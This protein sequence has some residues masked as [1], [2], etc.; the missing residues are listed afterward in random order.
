MTF[1]YRASALIA[2]LTCSLA[3][4]TSGCATRQPQ[5]FRLSFLPSTPIPIEPTFEAPPQFPTNLY[6]SDTP[7]L[8]QRALALA[9]RQAE[10]NSRVAKAHEH[11]E[12]GK[13]FYQ[14]N[15]LDASRREFDAALDVLL[16]APDTLPDRP[17]LEG[18]LDQIADTIYH[19]D[20][21]GLGA[22]ASGQSEV[23]YD[24]SP[25]DGILDMTF[26]TD[27]NL[28]PKV[29]EEIAA[30]VS[31][32]PLQE[33]D[34]VLSYVHYFSTDRGRQVLLGGLRRSGRYRSLVQRILD[35]E[36]VP[37]ELIY[38][39][40][41]ESG[42]LPRAR[43][44]KQAVGMWQFVQFRGRQYGLMQTPG[45]DDRLDP[46][47]ATR[48]AAKHLHDLYAMFGDWYLAMAA[49]NCG[50]GCVQRAVERTG[51]ADF[52]EL[53]RLNVLPRET[54]NYVPVIVA[55]TIMAK[56]P[57]DYDLENLDTDRPVEYETM[58]LDTPTSMALVADAV[59]R[60]VSEIQ[61]LNPALLKSAAPAGYQLRLPKGALATL[62]MALDLVPANHRAD[63]RIHRVVPGETL[64]EIAHRYSTPL[65][66]LT[67]ANQ[68]AAVA[69]VAGADQPV[70]GDLLVIPT[71]SRLPH[72]I[73]R[74]AVA[75]SSHG[76]LSH[77][78]MA[79]RRTAP[80]PAGTP[81]RRVHPSPYHTASLASKHRASAN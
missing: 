38:L 67:S 33:N 52:W 31:Q 18:E 11:L 23:V 51:Y 12:A 26:P 55:L 40:Q 63:W 54:A 41:V 78:A 58:D 5:A 14:L 60:P 27:P 76:K 72:A 3:L 15:D 73:A 6:S 79:A 19:Y 9:S 34:A 56:N 29:K 25:L 32:L 74:S 37:Q 46:E 8:V 17:R 44:N 68:R 45:T 2:V 22:A 39:A 81:A 1:S 7:D 66:A 48:A 43:S 65:S 80:T 10:V 36:G 47:R 13:R 61:E 30:T 28:R 20:L 4:L 69:D 16:S 35:D 24:K 21:E 59:D 50:P 70:A 71:A 75:G 64:A 49:Y 62:R 77:K 53:R 42:F 57:K